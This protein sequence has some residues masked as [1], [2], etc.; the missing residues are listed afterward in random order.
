MYCPN[1]GVEQK[2]ERPAAC[3]GCALPLGTVVELLAANRTAI[4]RRESET[5]EKRERLMGSAVF[6]GLVAVN[7]GLALRN[8]FQSEP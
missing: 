7:I 4:A 5:R 3:E 2:Q 8:R 1:C 6:L